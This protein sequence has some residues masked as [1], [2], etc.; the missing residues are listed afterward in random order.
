VACPDD[1]IGC[2]TVC[3]A[4]LRWPMGLGSRPRLA[5]S[6]V[7]GYS[8]VCFEIKWHRGFDGVL[9]KLW[10]FANTGFRGAQSLVPT[11]TTDN[12]WRTTACSGRLLMALFAWAAKLGPWAYG[13]RHAKTSAQFYELWLTRDSRVIPGLTVVSVLSTSNLGLN[14]D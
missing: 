5:G 10:P 14:W 6:F 9:F 8:G 13:L 1:A 3:A 11:W 7:S 12:R 2:V 4:W